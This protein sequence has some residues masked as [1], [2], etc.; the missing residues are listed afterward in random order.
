MRS[1]FDNTM[2][3]NLSAQSKYAFDASKSINAINPDAFS[4]GSAY[5]DLA[6]R[7]LVQMSINNGKSVQDMLE[8]NSHLQGLVF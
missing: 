5:D 7:S 4:S 1:A 2:Q 3:T 6:Q 8:E